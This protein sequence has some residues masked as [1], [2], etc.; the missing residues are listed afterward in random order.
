[1]HTAQRN[2]A[3]RT[4]SSR[5]AGP[6]R[7]GART[8]ARSIGSASAIGVMAF[9]GGPA[10]LPFGFHLEGQPLRGRRVADAQGD[11]RVCPCAVVISIVADIPFPIHVDAGQP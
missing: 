9:Q 10:S 11:G 5:E 1:M 8:C 6:D 4:Y 2:V 7:A 3:R